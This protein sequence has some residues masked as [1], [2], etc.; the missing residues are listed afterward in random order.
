MTK[1]KLFALL[2]DV[3]ED[4]EVSI[5]GAD[6]NVIVYSPGDCVTLDEKGDPFED[7]VREGSCRV[8]F[9]RRGELAWV[10]TY[11]ADPNR[12]RCGDW[13]AEVLKKADGRLTLALSYGRSPQHTG[14]IQGLE[15]S[16]DW[17]MDSDSPEQRE[18]SD[19]VHSVL[20]FGACVKNQDVWRDYTGLMNRIYQDYL[21]GG[22]EPC[23]YAV[24]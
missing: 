1:R 9:D 24:G 5:M 7:G 13:Q 11:P 3:P 19:W 15:G 8:L 21:K 16:R 17:W 20:D 22:K 6:I 18:Y 2:A 14:V 23:V 10:T 12:Y 4:A